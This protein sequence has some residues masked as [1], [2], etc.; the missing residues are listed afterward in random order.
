V[1]DWAGLRAKAVAARQQLAEGP[2]EWPGR[3]SRQRLELFLAASPD[4]IIEL[5]DELD[6][7]KGGSP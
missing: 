7:L 2:R 6:R 1:T 5:L 3:P 4:T